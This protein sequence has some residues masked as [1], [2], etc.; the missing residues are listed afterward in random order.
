MSLKEIELEI[1][2]LTDG[3]A[4]EQKRHGDFVKETTIKLAEAERAKRIT[5]KGIDLDRIKNAESVLEVRGLSNEFDMEVTN[6][7]IADIAK[8]GELIRKQYFGTKNYEC[9]H[10][11]NCDCEYMFGPKH[12]CIVFSIGLKKPGAILADQQIE[13]CLYYL[14]MITDDDARK[15]IAGNKK[16]KE[17]NP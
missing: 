9:Y 15:T 14:N 17:N 1:M 10:H 3:L 13:D 8:G 6:R 7:A 11:Q 12:G 4:E 16:N 5:L 2:R